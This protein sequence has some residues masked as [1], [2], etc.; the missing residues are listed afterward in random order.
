MITRPSRRFPPPPLGF[1]FL[2]SRLSGFRFL[3]KTAC[4]CVSVPAPLWGLPKRVCS[5][6]QGL[7]MRK[8][9]IFIVILSLIVAAM[10]ALVLVVPILHIG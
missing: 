5:N 10:F 3:L 2:A 9:L 4:R 8:T 6:D 1:T 7:A